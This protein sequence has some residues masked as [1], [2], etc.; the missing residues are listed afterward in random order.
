MKTA[1]LIPCL[2]EV[3]TIEKVINQF[4]VCLEDATI[5]VYDNGSTDGTAEKAENAGAKVK[6]EFSLGKGNV[7]RR[8]F[9][10]ID[11]DVYL[12]I[13]GDDTYDSQV[14]KDLVEH[15]INEDL[16]MVVGAREGETGRT[17]HKTGNKLFN[18]LYC[19]LFGNGFTDIFSGYRVFSRAFVKSFPATSTGFEIETEMSVHASQLCL[20]SSEIITRYSPRPEGSVSKL[21]T[22]PDG[23]KILKA[24]FVLLSEN[25]PLFF[26]GFLSAV[27]ALFAAIFGIPVIVE[28]GDTGLVERL[29][30]AILATGL[31]LISTFLLAVGMLL[32]ALKRSRI[33]VK[34]I[35][36]LQFR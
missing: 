3:S 12:L 16:D 17:G 22:I 11:A 15:L 19:W 25:R 31:V 20:P 29:P 14:V 34:R 1:V 5:Y 8:M 26:F 32:D 6:R 23:F 7:V 18:R 13:D 4:K 35:A 30:T 9:A 21:R 33:E 28:Y 10:E 36:Y 24:I 2:N 27:S